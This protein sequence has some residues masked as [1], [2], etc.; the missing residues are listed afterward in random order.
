[1][2]KNRVIDIAMFVRFF[3]KKLMLS[4]LFLISLSQHQKDTTMKKIF[5]IFGVALSVIACKPTNE[6]EVKTPVITIV[7][8]AHNSPCSLDSLYAIR[9]INNEPNLGLKLLFNSDSI[10]RD[11]ISLDS[12]KNYPNEITVGYVVSN[13]SQKIRGFSMP[14]NTINP[15]SIKKDTTIYSDI[16]YWEER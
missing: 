2:D 14:Q 8:R 12:L 4:Y 1:M 6:P 13:A 15:A 5:V 16:T 3:T 7:V 9:N 11:I 10:A